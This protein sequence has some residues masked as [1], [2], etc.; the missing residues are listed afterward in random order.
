MNAPV[1]DDSKG[2]AWRWSART[3]LERWKDALRRE[4]EPKSSL[5]E[6]LR[7]TVA[8]P[9]ELAAPATTSPPPRTI[10]LNSMASRARPMLGDLLAK[11]KHRYPKVES[12]TAVGMPWQEILTEGA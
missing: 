9:H 1:P 3:N 2:H 12:I 5:G 10:A 11:T 6:A 4:V 8:A 7:Y